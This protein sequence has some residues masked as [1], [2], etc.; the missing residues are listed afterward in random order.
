MELPSR[1][2]EG[3]LDELNKPKSQQKLTE[4]FFIEMERALTTVH[5]A[6]P[7]IIED[8]DRVRDV[9]ISKY[10]AGTIKNITDFRNLAKIARAEKV[11]ISVD[12]AT[13][14]AVIRKVFQKNEYSVEQ[15]YKDSVS[16]AYSE[17]D[18]LTRIEGLVEKLDGLNPESMDDALR[19]ALS[20]LFYRLSAILHR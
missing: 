3:L 20:Q 15:A 10:K 8:K 19:G 9:L 13:A 11:S 1:Y 4:D 18:L 7:T 5:R 2:R 17:R 12:P 6:L 14:S 16:E